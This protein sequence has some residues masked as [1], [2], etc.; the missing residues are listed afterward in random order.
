MSLSFT[1]ATKVSH[2]FCLVLSSAKH[3]LQIYSIVLLSL[4]N[5]GI[6]TILKG[7][8]ALCP[9]ISPCEWHVGVEVVV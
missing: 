8:K 5:P 9:I 3:I 4:F 1:H 2:V 7:V 6:Y